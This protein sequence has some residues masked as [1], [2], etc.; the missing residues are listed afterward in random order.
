MSH[1]FGPY[2]TNYAMALAQ[3]KSALNQAAKT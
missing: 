2:R 1:P 3:L